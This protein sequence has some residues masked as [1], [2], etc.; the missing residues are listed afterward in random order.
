[1]KKHI[2]G[3]SVAIAIIGASAGVSAALSSCTGE[4]VA[5]LVQARKEFIRE[6]I[7]ERVFRAH[8]ILTHPDA[9]VTYLERVLCERAADDWL[10]QPDGINQ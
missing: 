9:S 1:M 7:V 6:C 5:E 2:I 4:S 10:A 3:A 8:S